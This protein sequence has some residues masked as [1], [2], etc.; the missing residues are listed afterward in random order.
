MQA[1][2]MAGGEGTRLR[3]LTIDQPKPLVPILNEPV[4]GHILRLLHRHGLREVTATL[5]YFSEQIRARF[6]D[7]QAWG[8]RLRYSVENV[9]L[10]TAGSVRLAARRDEP[11]LVISGDALTDMDLTALIRFHRERGAMATLALKQVSDPSRFGVVDCA[12]D[13]R[14][15]RFVEKPPRGQAFSNT[16]NTGIYVLEPEVL[17][18]IPPGQFFDFARDLFPVMLAQG[19]PMYGWVSTHYWCDVGTLRQYLAANLMAAWGRVRL[20]SLP[21]TPVASGDGVLA[22]SPGLRRRIQA[23]GPVEVAG[24]AQLY[25]PV[26]LGEAAYV[27]AGATVRWSVLGPGAW[28]GP[29]AVVEGSVLLPGA[30][31]EPGARLAGAIAGRFGIVGLRPGSSVT[32]EGQQTA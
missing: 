19:L 29:G 5:R 12:P 4:M 15:L 11:I 17:D 30:R 18:L 10:G 26:V 3:P 22:G 20:E 24:S 23:Q 21:S 25:G 14:I 31:V 16:V 1:I 32:V 9:P 28:V 13:G 6:G 2:V 27:G 7:G 8:I